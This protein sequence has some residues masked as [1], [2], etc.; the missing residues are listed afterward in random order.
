[1]VFEFG[2]RN[3]FLDGR[4][5]RPANVLSISTSENTRAVMHCVPNIFLVFFKEL[6]HAQWQQ[7]QQDLALFLHGA[8][9]QPRLALQRW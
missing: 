7:R 6:T 1:M 8:K 2:L 4:A 5:R 3:S 9:R